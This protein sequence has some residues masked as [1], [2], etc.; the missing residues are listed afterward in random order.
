MILVAMAAALTLQRVGVV[1]GDFQAGLS[2][3]AKATYGA[4]ATASIDTDTKHGTSTSLRISCQERSDTALGQDINVEPG[5]LYQLTGWVKTSKVVPNGAP[6]FGTIQAQEAGGATILASGENH[7]GD[8]DWTHESVYFVGPES[9][10][11]RVALFLFGWGRGT[12]TAWFSDVK[13]E[14]LSTEK[15]PMRIT[16]DPLV[17]GRINPMQYG[18][19]IEYLCD[20]V[21]SMW[22]EKLYDT[23]FE[24]LTPYKFRFNA[25]TDFKEKAWYPFGQANRLKVEQDPSTFI[26]GAVSKHIQLSDGLPCEGGIAQDGISLKKG[27]RCKFSIYVKGTSGTG[28]M[29]VRLFHGTTDYASATLPVTGDW[30][31]VHVD[32][33]PSGS[34]DEGTFAITFHGPGSFWLDN[35]SLMPVDT[36]GGWRP[37][38]VKV[39][40][41]VKPAVI[42]VGG[43]VLDDANLGDFQW[44]DTIGDPDHRKPFQAWGGSQPMGAGLE[45]VVQLIQ[46]VKAEPLICVRFQKKQP[47]DAADEVEYFNGS[48]DTPMGALRAKNGHPKPYNIKYWQV[49]NEQSGESY[50]K[51]VPEFCKAMLDVDHKIELLT[52]FPHDPLIKM[53]APYVK[54]REPPSIRRGRSF[55]HAPTAQRHKGNDQAERRW[56]TDQGRR[57]RVEHDGGRYRSAS[58]EAVDA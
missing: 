9:G 24:G 58:R 37:D 56:E 50:W 7:E 29:E 38:V 53:A 14:A 11:A 33:T 49:G 17:P 28:R 43:S 27:R 4:E 36:V 48:V 31:K 12:G 47:K 40:T 55:R 16:R 13:I 51:A 23:S 46:S 44:S 20:L 15:L 30:Q 32:L 1:N 34:T 3:W 22:A 42:R 21:P 26:S 41:A 5:R 57:D 18:Q 10:R 19:F 45:E 25:E 52:S 2:G 6:V 39:L 35:A 54:L 8:T